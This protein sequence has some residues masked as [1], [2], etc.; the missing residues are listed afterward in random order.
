MRKILRIVC[1]MFLFLVNIDLV[2]AEDL[3]C[4]VLLKRG[5][6]GDDVSVLQRKLNKYMDCDLDVDGIF[7]SK[8]YACVV[9]FQDKY[10]LEVDGVVGPKTCRKIN[11]NIKKVSNSSDLNVS[12]NSL[13]VTSK[14]AKVRYKSSNNSDVVKTISRGNVLK[15]YTIVKNGDGNWYKI[16]VGSKYGYIKIGNTSRNVIL[17][18]IS[19]Q[20]LIYLKSGKVI[21]NTRVV[22]GMRGNHDTPTG[23]YTLE[24]QNKEKARTLRG[25]NDDGSKYSAYVDYWMP[26]IMSRGI[27]FHDASWREISEFNDSTYIY[28]G[29]HGC[30][31]MKS[32]DAKKLYNNVKTDTDVV[33]RK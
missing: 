31:N 33:I 3:N 22:T 21:L 13:V 4:N 16:K 28:D 10:N 23:K 12:N 19:E 32:E 18:D 14:I 24:V 7:G 25:Y 29:S 26:F 9:K 30:I 17:V 20:K 1:V 5:S 15:Y 11:S 6:K 2:L 8:T 27:G